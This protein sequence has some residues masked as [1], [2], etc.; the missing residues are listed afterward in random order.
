MHGSRHA[1]HG[2]VLASLKH[3]AR[4]AAPAPRGC[5]GVCPA[6][7]RQ[8]GR[9]PPG[10]DPLAM[11]RFF[12]TNPACQAI[13]FAGQADGL[14]VRYQRR[15]VPLDTRRPGTR[16][17]GSRVH[18]GSLGGGG[19]G[20][21]PAARHGYAA[22]L[23]HGLPDQRS[24]TTPEVPAA[25]VDGGTAPHPAQIRQVQ[26]GVPVKD[27]I[28]PVPRVL[29]SAT[30]TGPSPSGSAEPARLCQ[31]CSRPPRHHP[32]QAVLSFT[33][34]LRQT[35]GEGLSPPLEPTAPHGANGNRA[36]AHARGRKPRTVVPCCRQATCCL[37]ICRHPGTGSGFTRRRHTLPRRSTL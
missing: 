31:G 1:D 8:P 14:T 19:P 36:R 4:R 17:G 33:G 25:S 3:Y 5:P 2:A 26:A 30:L 11:R 29:L 9:R 15:S 7:A 27:V 6:A 18:C 10:T 32:D 35:G 21:V 28:T 12:C 13:T 37:L 34:L 16:P 23:P 24:F 20:S 22:G